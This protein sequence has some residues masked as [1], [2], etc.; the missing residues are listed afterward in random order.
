MLEEK[1]Q[2][3]AL[4]ILRFINYIIEIGKASISDMESDWEWYE[5]DKWKIFGVLGDDKL[6][7][8]KSVGELLEIFGK[9]ENNNN[10]KV[11]EE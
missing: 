1:E 3:R 2:L 10:I 7:D 8:E 6:A 4:H 9:M 5:Y 11:R